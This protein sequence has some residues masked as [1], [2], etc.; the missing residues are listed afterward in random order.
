MAST[1]FGGSVTPPSPLSTPPPKWLKLRQLLS[2]ERDT[3]SKKVIKSAEV[4]KSFPKTLLVEFFGVLR[5]DA[6]L[7]LVAHAAHGVSVKFFN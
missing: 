3:K 5:S 4:K 2:H 1:F 7:I 6:Q